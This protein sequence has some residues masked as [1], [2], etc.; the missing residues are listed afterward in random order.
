[1][2]SEIG[3]IGLGNMGAPMAGRLVEAGYKLVVSDV[4]DAALGQQPRPALVEDHQ[5][6]SPS[7]VAFR[8][9][10]GC[11]GACGG[12]GAGRRR[13]R[14]TTHKGRGRQR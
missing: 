7:H 1:M 4:N 11:R 2:S 3:F 12:L 14:T 13:G 5:P 8:G 10:C 6:D 9:R